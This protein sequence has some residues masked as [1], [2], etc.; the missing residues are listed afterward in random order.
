M[1][2]DQSSPHRDPLPYTRFV[3]TYGEEAPGDRFLVQAYPH[4][5]FA[6]LA[7]VED[8][9][10]TYVAVDLGGTV[11]SY[12]KNRDGE[13]ARHPRKLAGTSLLNVIKNVTR[14]GRTI[15]TVGGPRRVYARTGMN[16][17]RDTTIA[18]PLP[19]DFLAANSAMADCY[20]NDLS[21]FSETDIYAAGGAGEVWHYEGKQWEQMSFPSIERLYNICCAGDGNVY[22]AGNMGS[23]YVGRK[24]GWKK[25]S[26]AA[27]SAPFK[28][29]AWFAG[30]LWCG[31]DCGL[32][33]FDG[34][35]MVRAKV[36][37]DV[38]LASGAIDISPDGALMLTA[39]ANGAALFDGNAWEVLF[40][41]HEWE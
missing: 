12:D 8:P 23:L 2:E 19:K 34:Q 29:I 24:N 41:R 16:H 17:W 15:Y 10:P 22:V 27:F 25:L 33:T 1:V 32:W 5:D 13:E 9:I 11:Y 4:F 6:R 37:V 30:K 20:W 38:Q 26:E 21:G 31:S 3:F 18:I 36:P 40:N 28:D 35:D 14:I 7:F 39:S